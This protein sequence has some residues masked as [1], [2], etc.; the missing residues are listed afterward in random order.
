MV[1]IY[2]LG[3][4]MRSLVGE[5][6]AEFGSVLDSMMTLFRCF[7]DGCAA[8]DGTPLA[9]RLKKT[10]GPIVFLGY[11]LVMMLVTVGIFN[12][13]MAMFIDKAVSAAARRKQKEL[14]ANAKET[15]RNLKRMV[16]QLAMDPSSMKGKGR[17]GIGGGLRGDAEGP[18][19]NIQRDIHGLASIPH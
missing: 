1:L 4:F 15:E 6:E 12:M 13:I 17:T 9:D 14:S 7:V 3:I 5:Q 10:Y 19:Q 16:A 8:Y 11:I 18:D 2:V